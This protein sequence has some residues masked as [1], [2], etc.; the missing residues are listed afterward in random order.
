V[1]ITLV[2][3]KGAQSVASTASLSVTLDAPPTPGNFLVACC[4]SDA[5]VATPA[6]FEVAVSAVNFSG[7]YIFYR[8]VQSGDS[9]T[10][11]FTPSVSDSVAA[12]VIEYSGLTATPLD[13]TA[14]N[15][16]TSSAT[17]LF[18]GSAGATSQANEL[19]IVVVGPHGGAGHPWVFSSWSGAY[20]S[21]IEE[22][23]GL[24]NSGA[25]TAACHI[26]D[27]IVSSIVTPS[28]TGTWSPASGD[29]AA[30][31]ATFKV[32]AGQVVAVGQASEI[33]T[34]QQIRPLRIHAIGQAA[35]IDTAFGI[36]PMRIVA[37]GTAVETDSAAALGRLKAKG[38]GRAAETDAAF[39]I[40]AVKGSAV[41][42]DR[43]LVGPLQTG[44]IAEPARAST[45]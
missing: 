39:A 32:A 4:N 11:T 38:I 12:G 18:T 30:A 13:K 20:A 45:A 31:I 25:G 36:R 23:N 8:V 41:G 7:L 22:P 17:S 35:E 16:T 19:I 14:S 24:E 5:T 2:Q 44:W 29:A 9:A 40:G 28:A 34:A 33:D 42:F 43:L 10:V 3:K 37:L 6:G 26:G 21:Q 15:T 27:Q 1:G